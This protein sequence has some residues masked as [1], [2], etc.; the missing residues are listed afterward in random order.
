MTTSKPNSQPS[1]KPTTILTGFLGAGKT[2]FLNHLLNKKSDIRYAIIENEYGQES[3]DSELILRA[4]DDII[5]LN[6]GCLCC[7]LNDNLYEILNTLYE[8]SDEYDELIIEATGVADPRGL[9]APFI[10]NYAIKKQFPLTRIICL[11]DAEQVEQQI[12]HT[13]E[14]IHQ[15]TFSDVLLINKTDLVDDD[16]LKKLDALLTKLNPLAEIIYGNHERY[17]SLD[18]T[19]RNDQ[20]NEKEIRHAHS[21]ASV[22]DPVF[23]VQQPHAHH[24]HDHT[25]GVASHTLVFDQPFDYP[26]LHLR[27]LSFLTFQAKGLYRMKGLIWVAHSDQQML[28]QTVGSRMS[29]EEKRPWEMQETKGSRIVV[30]GKNFQKKSLEKMFSQ[31]FHKTGQEVL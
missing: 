1:T 9:A 25:D 2:T 20:L 14:A 12:K 19:M 23:P 31:C 4:E 3:I 21:E 8:R 7:T 29:I 22:A 13:E 26:K 5:E 16:Q 10:N 15:I 6:N 17:P 30:I 11:V 28:L 18:T 27:L 24:D